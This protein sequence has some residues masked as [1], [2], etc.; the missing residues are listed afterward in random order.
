MNSTYT[1]VSKVLAGHAIPH[2]LWSSS[3]GLYMSDP[4]F[5][6]LNTAYLISLLP[7]PLLIGLVGLL[8]VFVF[9]VAIVLRLLLLTCK[10]IVRKIPGA[11][12]CRLFRCCVCCRKG[13]THPESR[14]SRCCCC[15][16]AVTAIS[17]ERAETTLT[18]KIHRHNIKRERI[19]EVHSIILVLL[20][21]TD[22]M[23]FY[24]QQEISSA[25]EHIVKAISV[26][27]E[28][29]SGVVS[30]ASSI[31]LEIEAVA[32]ALVTAPCSPWVPQSQQNEVLEH[33]AN[34]K[35]AS[36]EILR[37]AAPIVAKLQD[38]GTYVSDVISP[39]VESVIVIFFLVVVLVVFLYGAGEYT[40]SRLLMRASLVLSALI[41]ISLTAACCLVMVL[42]TV[43]ADFCMSPRTNTLGLIGDHSSPLYVE[44]AYYTSCGGTSQ[45]P[46]K[47]SV[48]T[49]VIQ[50]LALNNTFVQISG[51]PT[52]S[53]KCSGDLFSRTRSVSTSV[54]QINSLISCPSVYSFW[55]E[56]VHLGL[57][58]SGYSGFFDTW[59]AFFVCSGLLFFAMVCAYIFYTWFLRLDVIGVGW[60]TDEEVADTE[61]YKYQEQ[62]MHIELNGKRFG[63][64]NLD[65]EEQ[66]HEEETIHHPDGHS[67]EDLLHGDL[68][69]LSFEHQGTVHTLRAIK[70]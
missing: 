69:E 24:G 64:G 7:L 66:Q 54:A 59:L 17:R 55:N 5:D 51:L 57:C 36:T 18:T 29:F 16:R 39:S 3:S 47:I 4:T 11:E 12:T 38:V 31:L 14:C 40:Q 48:D 32:N 43:M 23:V 60:F 22:G 26:V 68:V 42:L 45:N 2:L 15:H 13:C 56:A 25:L 49:S 21:V 52:I 19:M 63:F 10:Y 58:D 27:K 53:R 8:F 46:Y 70:H 30:A 28:I 9:L 65:D 61:E 20:L 35:T 67:P 44:L 50:N 34:L 62:M 41:V 37:F 6:V 33:T 1:P